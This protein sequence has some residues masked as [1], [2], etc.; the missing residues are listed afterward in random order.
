MNAVHSS[1]DHHPDLMALRAG[2][3][4]TAE[5]MTGQF[6]FGLTLLTAVYVALSPWIIG[7]NTTTGLTANNFIVGLMVAALAFGYGAALDRTHVLLW[8][9]PVFGVWTIIAPWILHG[10]SPTSA[11]IWS[12]VVAGGLITVLGVA[13]YFGT[14]MRNTESRHE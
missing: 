11:M 9:L 13:A 14:R 5:S 6:T 12:N 4:W 7:F 2:Y 1:I 3:D 10:I 8:T